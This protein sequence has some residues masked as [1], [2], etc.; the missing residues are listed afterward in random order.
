MRSFPHALFTAQARITNCRRSRDFKVSRHSTLARAQNKQPKPNVC[1]LGRKEV[2]QGMR[3]SSVEQHHPSLW[4]MIY[5]CGSCHQHKRRRAQPAGACCSTVSFRPAIPWWV[6]PQ[7]SPP[8]LRRPAIITLRSESAYRISRSAS[9]KSLPLQDESTNRFCRRG[10][11][12]K[13]V[14]SR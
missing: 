11:V 6:A 14:A 8:P 3:K 10:K 1:G 4:L 9:T 13:K 7:Q 2:F 12:R 5:R